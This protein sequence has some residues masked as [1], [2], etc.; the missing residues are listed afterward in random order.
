[1]KVRHSHDDLIFI[2]GS[3]IFGKTVYIKLGPSIPA[4]RRSNFF[5]QHQGWGPI[6]EQFLHPNS[7]LMEFS[8]CS[9]PKWG[10]HYEILYMAWQLCCHCIRKNFVAIWFSIEFELWW[11][12]FLKSIPHL[13]GANRMLSIFNP[14]NNSLAAPSPSRVIHCQP[15][16]GSWILIDGNELGTIS[17]MIIHSKF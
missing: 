6:H 16:R 12:I 15:N 17:S 11:I 1:M 8:F 14:S 5:E 9:N 13:S 7:N 10:D 2:M 4:V 3:L